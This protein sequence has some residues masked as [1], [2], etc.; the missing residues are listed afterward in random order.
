MA[1]HVSRTVYVEKIAHTCLVLRVSCV[2]RSSS[3]T[4][5]DAIYQVTTTTVVTYTINDAQ[6]ISLGATQQIP[7]CVGNIVTFRC[8]LVSQL[9]WQDPFYMKCVR[10][11]G[12]IT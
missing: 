12:L 3:R 5:T 7:R 11:G 4:L 2:F 9:P 8:V 6:R 1:T 10:Y